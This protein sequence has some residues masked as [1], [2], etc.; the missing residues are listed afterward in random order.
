MTMRLPAGSRQ[1]CHLPAR[2]ERTRRGESQAYESL[3]RDRLADGIVGGLTPL[4]AT[5]LVH[6][7][8]DDL[9]PAFMIMAAAVISFAA[10]LTFRTAPALAAHDSA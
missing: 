6:R 8:D 5:W 1:L 10:V 4:V 2:K 9:S 3:E 7:T